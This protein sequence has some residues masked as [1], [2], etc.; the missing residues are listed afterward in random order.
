MD[1]DV[2]TQ[3]RHLLV[4]GLGA[5]A[6]AALLPGAICGDEGAAASR[7]AQAIPEPPLAQA[8]APDSARVVQQ[9]DG[10]DV[11]PSAIGSIS[12]AFRT[13]TFVLSD[14]DFAERTSAVARPAGAGFITFLNGLDFAF[15]RADGSTI[16][17]ER[18]LG[19]FFANVG[20]R[21]DNLVCTV[22]L[23]DRNADDPV[24]VVVTAGVLFWTA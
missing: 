15:V 14:G 7:D 9:A 2:I 3:R 10:F 18:P 21:G 4:G 16:L 11:G 17:T 1:P 12:Q 19:Q 20:L 5:G 22:R 23:T 6:L 13:F 24:R 8:G